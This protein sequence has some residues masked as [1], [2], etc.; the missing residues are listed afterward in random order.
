MLTKLRNGRCA[1]VKSAHAPTAASRQR[2]GAKLPQSIDLQTVVLYD[3]RPQAVQ[4]GWGLMSGTHLLAEAKYGV[5][6]LI[7]NRL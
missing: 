1:N 3:K 2:F 6:L 4:N 7:P 5:K